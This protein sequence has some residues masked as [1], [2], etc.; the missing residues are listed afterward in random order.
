MTDRYDL[1]WSELA[2]GSKKPLKELEAIFI[3]APREISTARFTQL[4][5][6]NLSKGNIVLGL[7][8]ED[9]IDGFEGQPHFRTLKSKT[10]QTIIDK[11]N[12]SKSPHKI[13]TL[14]YF[15]RELNHI[16]EKIPFKHHLFVN[17]SW[18]KAFHNLPQYYTLANQ[19]RSYQLISPFDSETEAAAY[20]KNTTKKIAK[21]FPLP[22]PGVILSEAEMV[23]AALKVAAYSFDYNF[24]TGVA[25]GKPVK[26]GYAFLHAT[27]NAVVP[28]QAYALH[29]GAARETHFSPPHD[30]NHYDTV[31]AE[32]E[33][34]L[35]AG[36]QGIDLKGASFFINT[37]PCPTCSRMLS[38]TD[39]KE[40][41][42]QN[43]H[44][45]GYAIKM[46]ESAGKS[47]RYTT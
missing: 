13:Y 42:Y 34:I 6:D 10:V 25:L 18:H 20:T 14:S 1:D 36:R 46:L 9:F 30:V 28:Y 33:M 5:K 16:L 39:I 37:L 44:S 38:Q 12:A 2:F 23:Q 29:H 4:V 32:V 35:Q 24:Q 22:R 17:G 43:D 19:H 7:A 47:V 3:A 31:H 41:I 11:V 45:A 40:F 26:N 15:Q 8:K 21:A 27:Y